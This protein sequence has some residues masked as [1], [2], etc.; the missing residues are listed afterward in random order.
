MGT[1]VHASRLIRVVANE[2]PLIFKPSY[3][4]LGIPQ[5]QILWDYVLHFQQNRD[6]A[7][8]LLNKFSMLVFKTALGDILEGYGGLDQLDSRM[9]ML[10]RTQTNDGVFAIDR[11]AEDVVKV[12]TPLSGV[13][14]IVKQSLEQLAAMNRT[15]AV[16]LLGISPSGF[17]ATG[18]SDLRNYYDHVLSQQEKILRHAIK[19][20]LDVMQISL[21]GEVDSSIAFTFKPLSEDDK[22]AVAMTQQVKVNTL[23]ALLDREVISPEEAR[24]VLVDD[25]ASGMNDLDPDDV[26]EPKEGA[27]MPGMGMPGMGGEEQTPEGQAAEEDDEISLGRKL[28]G[29]DAEPEKKPE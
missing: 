5:A 21:F 11:E 16:K 1:E 18:E 12:E 6:A 3:N 17:N 28:L 9:Q 10:A 26:P 19:D 29:M 7:N 2:A 14:D 24:R 4:F 22:N 15:P 23:C 13:T 20:I 8:R 27:G 25:P